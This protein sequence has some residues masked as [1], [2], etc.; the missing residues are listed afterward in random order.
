MSPL[1][2]EC[3]EQREEVAYFMRRLYKQGLT[4]CSGGNISVR[5]KQYVLIT[6]SGL[7]KGELRGEQIAVLTMNG[8]NIT[9]ELKT[10]IETEMHLMVLEARP[11]V[12]AV[13]HAHPVTATSFTAMKREIDCRLTAEAYAV[14]G[15]PKFAPYALMGTRKLAEIVAECI[16]ESD[17]VTMENHGIL[18]VGPTLLKAFDRLEVLEAAAK[19]TWITHTMQC[20]SPLTSPLTKDMLEEMDAQFRR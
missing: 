9:P 13:V 6:P 11:D 5:Y 15:T 20:P 19:M 7:D 18:T 8:E 17:V 14:L 2:D 16:K 4:T 1:F 10:S 12:H 3:L